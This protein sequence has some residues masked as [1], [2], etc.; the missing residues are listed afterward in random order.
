MYC[1]STNSYVIVGEDISDEKIKILESTLRVPVIHTKIYGT[2]FAGIFCTGN[3]KNL[4]VPD[5][6]FDNEFKTLKKKLNGSLK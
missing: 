4:L 6:I 2:P 3:S 5:I 1:L